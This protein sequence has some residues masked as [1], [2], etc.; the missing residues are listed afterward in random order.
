MKKLIL[1]LVILTSFASAK[2]SCRA[3]R[4]YSSPP[5]VW[6]DTSVIFTDTGENSAGM[7]IVQHRTT[8]ISEV[9]LCLPDSTWKFRD[10]VDTAKKIQ[11]MNKKKAVQDSISK[12]KK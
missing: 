1:F 2:V 9:N 5:I 7:N 6:S 12:K 4:T 3:F 11:E 10:S 8:S